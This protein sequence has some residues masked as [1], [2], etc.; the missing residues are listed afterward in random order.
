MMSKDS[1]YNT[2]NR[3][4]YARQLFYRL[5]DLK[6]MSEQQ[7]RSTVFTY[8]LM[9]EYGIG[10]DTDANKNKMT[11]ENL[12][13]IKDSIE[14]EAVTTGYKAKSLALRKLDVLLTLIALVESDNKQ[15]LNRLYATNRLIDEGIVVYNSNSTNGNI[16]YDI[17]VDIDKTMQNI[18]RKKEEL[19]RE[20]IELKKKYL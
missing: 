4:W 5:Y 12:Y 3:L 1:S 16:T 17:T 7:L 18:A 2:Y 10:I 19:E 20:I 15:A 8:M 11:L 14:K 13:G 9:K 6:V